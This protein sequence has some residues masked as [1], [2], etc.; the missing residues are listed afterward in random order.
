MRVGEPRLAALLVAHHRPGFYLRVTIEGRVQA[1]DEIIRTRAGRHRLSV[2]DVDALLYLPGRDRQRLREAVDIPALSPGWSQSFQH[3]LDAGEG[4]AAAGIPGRT[5]PGWPGFHRLRVERLVPETTTVT[6]VYLTADSDQPLPR[7]RAGQYLTLRVSGTEGRPAVRSYSL[8]SAPDAGNYRISVK[9]EDHGV[10]SR[11]VHSQLRQGALVD[12]AAPR[13]EFVLD[14]EPTPILLLS[15]GVGVTPVLAMLHQLASTRSTRDVWWLHVARNAS[16][17]IF[18]TEAHL[19]LQDLSNAH[20]HVFYSDAG[21]D[22]SAATW[23]TRGRPTQASLAGL[24]I[25]AD[26]TAYICGPTG[27][28]AD[29]GVALASVGVAAHQIH[30]ELFGALPPINPGVVGTGHVRPHPPSGKPGAGPEVTFVRSGLTVPWNGRHQS[31]LEFAE[32]CDV[33]TRFSCRTGVCHTCETQ[34]V[35]GDVTY[36]PLP[37]EAPAEPAVLLCCAQPA[38]AI[39]LDL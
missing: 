35:T 8:S 38:G 2:A 26:T 17:H 27:F 24:G 21:A 34:V 32:S 29:M 16:E 4:A 12:V 5:E 25:P 39:V 10:V 11:Y 9:I 6:S 30:T 36:D 14:D 7:P 13:G 19:L 3:L 22:T 1:G 33:P 15:A 28:M 31:L 23:I 20:E 37:L 18:A